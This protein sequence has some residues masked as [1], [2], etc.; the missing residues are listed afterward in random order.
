M[1]ADRLLVPSHPSALEA[2]PR[3]TF[4]FKV[5]EIHFPLVGQCVRAYH[6]DCVAQLSKAM[7]ALA[8]GSSAL[9]ARYLYLRGLVF[10]RLGQLLDALLDFQSLYKTDLG[11]FPADLVR[12]VV[13]AMSGPE[14]AQ[15][16]R[17]P[18]LR[19][20]IS[21]VLELPGEAPRADDRV[22]HFALPQTYLQLDEFVQRVQESGIVKDAG[23]ISRLFEA[24]TVGKGTDRSARG[25]VAPCSGRALPPC[26]SSEEQGR[27][28]PSGW[29][30]RPHPP[31][32]SG[33]Q[34]TRLVSNLSSLAG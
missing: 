33:S 12:Q 6:C 4:T 1:C 10:L 3:P 20:L 28:L 31:I 21:E 32:T 7:G 30:L 19:R 2:T 27:G 16:E 26:G 14:R 15:A 29:G 9:L 25:Q 18:E 17:R 5:P 34:A 24:L 8:P 11:V 22:K 23:I 13:R